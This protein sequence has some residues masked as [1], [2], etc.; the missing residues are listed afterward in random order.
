MR[1]KVST[2]EACFFVVVLVAANTSLF[3]LSLVA[4]TDA[5][6][7]L[8]KYF[9]PWFVQILLLRFTV[10]H[11][12]KCFLMTSISSNTRV[13]CCFMTTGYLCGVEG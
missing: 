2:C 3:N 11:R 6:A 12:A 5:L 4:K 8:K 7:S 1:I 9:I 13:F 10:G